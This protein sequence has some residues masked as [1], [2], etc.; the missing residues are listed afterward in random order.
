M[1]KIVINIDR[2][3]NPVGVWT[4]VMCLVLAAYAFFGGT[5]SLIG[6]IADVP[7]LADWGNHGISTL[8]NTAVAVMAAGASLVS[9]WRGSTVLGR[10]LGLIVALIG[11]MS[12]FQIATGIHFHSV[13]SFLMFDREWGR[14]GTLAPGQIGT[15]AAA[16]FTLIGISL[17]L[18][19]LSSKQIASS[20]STHLRLLS[21]GLALATLASSA[22]SVT[23]YL[24]GAESLYT[25]P[26]LTVIAFQTATFIFAIS[27][28][29]ILSVPDVGPMR[30]FS[31]DSIAGTMVRQVLP[32]LVLLPV[33]LGLVRLA[34][35]RA[36]LYDPNFAVAAGTLIEIAFLLTLLW[37][38]GRTVNREERRAD[39]NM[40]AARDRDRELRALAD[41]MPQ[42]VWIADNT[43]KVEYYNKRVE[44]FGGA[45]TVGEY[46]SSWVPIVHPHDAAGASD[47]WSEAVDHSAVYT[48]EHRIL[49]ADG[50]FRWHL[51]RAVKSSSSDAST[52]KWFGTAT[53]IH[54]IK[55]AEMEFR[56]TEERLRLAVEAGQLGVWES[57]PNSLELF[58]DDRTRELFGVSKDATITYDDT[59]WRV[60]PEEEHSIVRVAA[61]KALDPNGDGIYDIEHRV[62]LTAG[63]IRWL[64]QRGRVEFSDNY[65][66]RQ[67]L[68]MRG[69][70]VDITERKHEE[71]R[72]ALLARLGDLIRMSDDPEELLYA[73]S[74]SVGDALNAHRCL[75]SEIDLESRIETGHRDYFRSGESVA[76]PRTIDDYS[77]ITLKEKAAGKTV[78]NGDSKTDKRTADYYDR[79]YGPASE[80]AYVAVPLMRGGTWVASFWVSDDEPRVWTDPEIRVIESIA[81]RTWLA[82]ERLRSAYELGVSQ[83]T[84]FRLIQEAPFGV[85]VVDSDF[86]LAQFSDFSKKVFSGIDPL[87]GRDFAEILRILWPEPLAT[88]SIVRF[89]HTLETGEPYHSADTTSNR[90][91]IDDVESYDWII[92]RILLPEGGYGVVCY[93]FDM[94]ERKRAEMLLR[95]REQRLRISTEAAELGV[96]E[97]N[98]KDDITVWEDERLHEIFGLKVGDETI[99]KQAFFTQYMHMEDVDCFLEALEEA[100]KTG[101]FRRALCRIVRPDKKVR[102]IEINGQFENDEAGTPVSLV[103]VVADVT[104]RQ[105]A[106]RILK[107]AEERRKLAEEAG[108]V[109]IW[110]WNIKEGRT[111]WSE[112]MWRLYGEKPS[113]LNPDDE[114]WSSH[115]HGEDRERVSNKLHKIVNSKKDDFR[116]EFR[117]VHPDGTLRWVQSIA[118][119][120]RTADG[121]ATRVSGV[122][123]DISHRKDAEQ[124]LQTAYDELEL[125][126]KERT[127]Q[128]A[129]ANESLLVEIQE[130]KVSERERIDLLHRLV[131]SQE[132]ERSRIARDIH[133]QLGQRLTALRMKIASLR[134]SAGSND[135]LASRIERLQEIGEKLDSEVS[136]LAWE[137]RPS[138][139]DDLGFIEAI[140]E[141]VREW[142]RHVEIAADFHASDLGGIRVG[143]ETETHLYRISQEALNNA[144]KHSGADQVSV[145]LERRD[146]SLIMVIEDNGKGFDARHASSHS[147]S[148]GGLGLI[149]MNER[150]S[151]VGGEVEIESKPGSGTTIYVRV[152]FSDGS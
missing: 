101:F 147:D 134:E 51:T 3:P 64:H 133:D 126:V 76:G 120:T 136:Y 66:S 150:A 54:E 87:I 127:E 106:E 71:T 116:E 70:V 108:N 145:L 27:L 86:R 83:K 89:R 77:P 59:I 15:P 68:R 152:P 115:V 29:M 50:S 137:L 124:K 104:E 36:G 102:W 34:G 130:R 91:N 42:V 132:V 21:V 146:S 17:V 33:L 129:N 100:K 25:L 23:G 38:A 148:G 20:V 46:G 4:R 117:I 93:F 16:S 82:V 48:H 151:L 97:W 122:N 109:G 69:T 94:T 119:V 103:G 73:A 81:E 35:E 9:F 67:P 140:G 139:L 53:D 58:W 99:S 84:F 28:A 31:E 24:F 118:R 26:Q 88:E 141:Y 143:R 39:L 40:L 125:R 123:L 22:L 6:W 8:P 32:A 37:W 85:Y 75:F 92:K 1:S 5:V 80:R 63:G 45:E 95:Y 14:G 98:I 79:A 49:M 19:S 113:K 72:V 131:T 110:D 121:T 52:W 30:L 60:I 61:V 44:E 96:F 74:Q 65:A 90:A 105:E 138:G 56:R 57:D 41:A 11:L 149:G 128:L 55:L 47:A 112:T 142:S 12:V 10:V 107:Q 18:I 114:F 43:G 62:R 13:N 2:E 135:E 78:I 144:A 111:Y 7:R